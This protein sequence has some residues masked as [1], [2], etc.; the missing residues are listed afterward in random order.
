MYV[1]IRPCLVAREAFLPADA[2]P[3]LRST[4]SPSVRSPLAS[5][6]ALLHSIIPAPVRS[7]SSF[8]SAAV[9]SAISFFLLLETER[10]DAR[11]MKLSFGYGGLGRRGFRGL[12]R[13]TL[14][15]RRLRLLGHAQAL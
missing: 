5:T 4:T 13:R 6:R 1:P 10:A 7:R 11:S 15:R 12:R 14:A 8:T 2:M 3:R 9:I